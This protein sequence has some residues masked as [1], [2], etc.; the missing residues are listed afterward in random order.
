MIAVISHLQDPHAQ[1]VLEV[2][3]GW[4]EPALLLDLAELPEA[5]LTIDYEE[6][7]KPRARYRPP[8]GPPTELTE[9]TAVW[10]RRPQFPRLEAIT[11]GDARAFAHGEWHEAL[12]GLWQLLECRWM[13]PPGLD[14]VASHKPLQLAVASRLGLRVPDTIMTSDAD[15][16]RAFVGRHGLG[17]TIYKIFSATYQV[18]RET[19]LVR[20]EDLDMLDS[21]SVAPVI[22]QE[23]IPAVA[24]LRVTVVGGE[25]FCLAIDSRGTGYEVDFRVDMASARTTQAEV[26]DTVAAALLRVMDHFGLAYGAFDLRLTPEGEYVFLEVNTA[27]EFLFAENATGLPIT[28]AVAAWLAGRG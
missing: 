13:N 20:A 16:A 15:E 27:G 21:L 8:G 5:T 10:W 24:D 7:A 6:P 23:Y 18:W 12:Y 9:A 11:E 2:L 17:H 3:A 19:R 28:E 4:G 26:P 14:Q 22:F 25:L 1:R